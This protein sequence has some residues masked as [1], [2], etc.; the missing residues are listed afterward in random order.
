MGCFPRK[1][2]CQKLSV[3]GGVVDAVDEGV[4]IG[5]APACG[6]KLVLAGPQ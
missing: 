1:T 2:L 5:Y 4:L 6:F 3:A